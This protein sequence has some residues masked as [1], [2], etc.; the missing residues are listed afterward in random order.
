V[1]EWVSIEGWLSEEVLQ[2]PEIRQYD[3]AIGVQL[4]YKKALM[5]GK[6]AQHAGSGI[7]LGFGVGRDAGRA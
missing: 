4:R 1:D 7:A 5:D 3:L 6:V 2:R